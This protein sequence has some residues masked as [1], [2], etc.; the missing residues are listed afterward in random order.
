MAMDE[1]P[2]CVKS[3][4]CKSVKGVKVT[5][6]GCLNV[7]R[8]KGDG[9]CVHTA[10]GTRP[11]SGAFMSPEAGGVSFTDLGGKTLNLTRTELYLTLHTEK[12]ENRYERVNPVRKVRI[13]YGAYDLAM[14]LSS[15]NDKDPES[16]V[17]IG[18]GRKNTGKHLSVD[19][20]VS[21]VKK[22]VRL[23]GIKKKTW[24]HLFRH[25]RA[26]E[27]APKLSDQ[28]MRIYFGWSPT[29][30]M[31]SHYSHLTDNQVDEILL[32]SVYGI[33]KNKANGPSL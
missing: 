24:L 30:E 5:E 17:W 1:Y 8:C 27:L 15:I 10:Q 31:P 23:S 16:F 33:K 7:G 28:A 12:T 29:S 22:A 3:V 4:Q 13:N 26:T 18:E 11:S 14:W 9:G 20:L 32:E 25:S 19:S 6:R 2:E 21:I